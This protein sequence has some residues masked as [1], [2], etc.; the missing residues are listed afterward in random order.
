MEDDP[1]LKKLSAWRVFVP[2]VMMRMDS[3]CKYYHTF[4]IE[5]QRIDVTDQG[6]ALSAKI[7]SFRLTADRFIII[8]QRS[9][10]FNQLHIVA[11][12]DI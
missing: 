8:R 10:W 3:S 12:T 7:M 11:S 4:R 9:K 2:Q 6:M 5:V 1:R